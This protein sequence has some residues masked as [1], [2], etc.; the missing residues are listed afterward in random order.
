MNNHTVHTSYPDIDTVRNSNF[1]VGGIVVTV[2]ATCAVALRFVARWIKGVRYKIDDWMLATS[3]IFHY[4][5]LFL[6]LFLVHYGLGAPSSKLSPATLVLFMK[7]LLA[8]ECIYVTTVLLIKTSYLLMYVRAFD[9]R[10][11]KISCLVLGCFICT[12]SLAI[13]IV[14]IFQCTP[15]ELAWEPKTE[16]TCISLKSILIGNAVPNI[17]TDIAILALPMAEVWKLVPTMELRLQLFAVFSLGFLV[18]FASIFRFSTLFRFD[19]DDVTGTLAMSNLWCTIE[20]ACGII[21]VCL[22]TLGP[23]RQWLLHRKCFGYTSISRATTTSMHQTHLSTPHSRNLSGLHHLRPTSKSNLAET[24]SR[25]VSSSQ[26]SSR[27]L[28]SVGL[29]RISS[30]YFP[31]DLQWIGH[32]ALERRSSPVNEGGYQVGTWA[33]TGEMSLLSKER[34]GSNR[35]VRPTLERTVSLPSPLA[36][37][38]WHR[39]AWV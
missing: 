12:W 18:V 7:A 29:A 9:N 4:A 30:S 27:P 16:G 37:P 17:I 33:V 10:S 11:M 15:I 1:G 34:R 6:F 19:A 39:D 8:F 5:L 31:D 3:M 24:K 2:V 22:P 36:S 20:C 35:A 28:E 25:R 13:L 26:P 21:S 23:V 38:R 14:T 32:L